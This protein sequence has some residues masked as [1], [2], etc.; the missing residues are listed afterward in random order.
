MQKI[1][2]PSCSRRIT[3]AR[4]RGDAEAT[5]QV[6]DECSRCSVCRAASRV[7]L[8]FDDWTRTRA[9]RRVSYDDFNRRQR[10]RR[11]ARRFAS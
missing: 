2:C 4:R 7:R 9:Q 8:S 6:I 3:A 11:Q 10:S 1:H 5:E